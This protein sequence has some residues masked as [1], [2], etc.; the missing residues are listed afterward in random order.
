MKGPF[1]LG[2]R[3][4]PGLSKLTEEAGEVCQVAGKIMGTGGSPDHWDGT[5]LRVRMAEEVADLSAACRAFFQ[6]N[7]YA[8]SPW[9]LERE[10]QKYRQF[11][12]WH[13]DNLEDKPD[14]VGEGPKGYSR[15]ARWFGAGSDLHHQIYWSWRVYPSA[16]VHTAFLFLMLGLMPFVTYMAFFR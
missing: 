8:G 15:L 12:A 11:I 14:E 16:M 5:D 6:L 1:Q 13:N 9:V 10:I 2:S 3:I 7:D 4:W